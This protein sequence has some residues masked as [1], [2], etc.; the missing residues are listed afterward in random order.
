MVNL[1]FLHQQKR[2]IFQACPSWDFGFA[3]AVGMVSPRLN[4]WCTQA[5]MR[6]CSALRALWSAFIVVDVPGRSDGAATFGP[7]VLGP[8]D[9]DRRDQGFI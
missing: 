3:L 1:R 5:E 2:E 7:F 9:W 6:V 8:I 4:R